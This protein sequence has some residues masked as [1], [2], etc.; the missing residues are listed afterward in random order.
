[1]HCYLGSR[2]RGAYVFE[3]IV[4]LELRS[5]PWY[6]TDKYYEEGNWRGT[7]KLDGGGAVMAAVASGG[8]DTR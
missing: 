1:M 3:G 7:W 4:Y 8:S 5:T 2:E 6:R